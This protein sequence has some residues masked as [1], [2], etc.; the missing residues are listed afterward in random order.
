MSLGISELQTWES[1]E[2][3]GVCSEEIC[4]RKKEP[5]LSLNTEA[6]TKWNLDYEKIYIGLNG[7]V[8]V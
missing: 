7:R 1:L 5:S 3:S 6:Q 4:P 8:L 2:F